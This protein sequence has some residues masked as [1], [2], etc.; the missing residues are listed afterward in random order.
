MGLY[1][2]PFLARMQPSIDRI[3]ARVEAPAAVARR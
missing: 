3:L 2:T 1:P